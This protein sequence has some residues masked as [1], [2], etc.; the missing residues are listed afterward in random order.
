MTAVF[1]KLSALPVY[2][3]CLEV[4]LFDGGLVYLIILLDNVTQPLQNGPA[5]GACFQADQLQSQA[6]MLLVRS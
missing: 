4:L 2:V 1:S 3:C 5:F 6:D